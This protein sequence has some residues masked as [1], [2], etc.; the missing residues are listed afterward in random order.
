M[1]NSCELMLVKYHSESALTHELSS[2]NVIAGTVK[3][4]G[5][6][7][8]RFIPIDSGNCYVAINGMLP[9]PG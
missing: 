6:K 4:I 7:I 1:K 5:H 3:N 2:K 8:G 9:S